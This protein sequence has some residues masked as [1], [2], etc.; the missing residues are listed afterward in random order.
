M[1]SRGAWCSGVVCSFS[2]TRLLLM[3]LIICECLKYG[4]YVIWKCF[5]TVYHNG[6]CL[7]LW[8]Y[9]ITGDKYLCFKQSSS[10]RKSVCIE[11]HIGNCDV[12]TGLKF[13]MYVHT[14]RLNRELIILILFSV[15]STLKITNWLIELQETGH[16]MLKIFCPML[17]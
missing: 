1:V 3:S 16:G 4:V 17:A 8:G 10:G 7:V 13:L 5:L 15:L 6:W 2:F 9:S 12:F 14:E 11:Q